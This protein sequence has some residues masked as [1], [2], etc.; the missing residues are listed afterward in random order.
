VIRPELA[1]FVEHVVGIPEK[2]SVSEWAMIKARKQ[3][4]ET[5]KIEL[6]KGRA[7]MMKSA[8]ECSLQHQERVIIDQ[9]VSEVEVSGRGKL[10]TRVHDGVMFNNVLIEPTKLVLCE[11][12][13]HQRKR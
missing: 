5:I 3:E 10:C 2:V 4:T 9:V 8:I 13:N 1:R 7:E 11:S 12:I 6:A